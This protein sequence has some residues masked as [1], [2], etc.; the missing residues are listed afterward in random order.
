MILIHK[1]FQ[2]LKQLDPAILLGHLFFLMLGLMALY[3]Y[4]ERTMSFDSATFSFTIAQTKGFKIPLGRWGCGLSQIMPLIAL[5]LG[6][7]L[8]VF[9]KVYSVGLIFIYYLGFLII[10]VLL[11]NKR[12]GLI[13]ILTLCLTYR[14]TF[15][16]SISEL[17]QGLAFVVVLYAMIEHL[18]KDFG[19]RKMLVFILSFG[20]IFS[21]YYFHQLLILAI[22]FVILVVY[23]IQKEYKNIKLIGLF[24][25]A[26]LWFGYKLM[27]ISKESYEGKKIPGKEEFLEQ[28]PNLF[29]LASTEYFIGHFWTE[30]LIPFLVG[31]ICL[32]FLFYQKR[33][34][35]FLL[36]VGYPLCYLLLI[37]ITYNNGEAPNMYEQYY[38]YFGFF[39]A[40][41]L[42]LVL[43]N[44]IKKK[45]LFLI[46]MPLLIFSLAKIFLAHEIPT[47]RLN[48][49]KNLAKEGLRYDNRKY[50]IHPK[51]FPWSYGWSPIILPAEMLLISSVDN[52]NNTVTCYVPSNERLDIDDFSKS[53]EIHGPKWLYSLM[54]VSVL[55]TNFFKLPIEKGYLLTNR[56]TKNGV[57]FKEKILGNQKWLKSLK[58]KAK[59]NGISLDEMVF[60]DAKF[61]FEEFKK[62]GEEPTLL[63]LK[64]TYS[65]REEN[66]LLEIESCIKDDKIW[67]TRIEKKAKTNNISIDRTLRGEA[68][69][70]LENY[71]E[72]E[73][74]ELGLK[75]DQKLDLEKPLNDIDKKKVDAWIIQIR[76]DST[77]LEIIREK[78]KQDNITVEEKILQDAIYM[79]QQE[80]ILQ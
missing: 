34:M 40:I 51:D 15:Y 58:T 46:V 49:I 52:S 80:N 42:V 18:F 12:V 44:S 61:L 48:Y 31:A 50:I 65:K 10:T 45:H 35:L 25:F 19:K 57:Y 21:L 16:F 60:R 9:L 32:G 5:K 38:I 63:K 17:S 54:N 27:F 78:A 53:G 68:V 4:Q 67:L 79:F 36:F 22:V 13:Y 64:K 6:C 73:L 30:L 70:L 71:N 33:Y 8:V 59:E 62:K 23:F 2:R 28:L 77:W 75:L 39:I 26:V 24:S 20:L 1:I 47:K 3:F 29:D 55:D 14:N 37:L 11:K 56:R 74:H 41:L 66:F 76:K 43:G 7:S 72:E 69:F